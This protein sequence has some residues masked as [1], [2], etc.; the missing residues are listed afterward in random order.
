[1]AT[2]RY[3]KEGRLHLS[4]CVSFDGGHGIVEA[5]RKFF[6]WE[7]KPELVQRE[8]G[9]WSIIAPTG[10]EISA[11]IVKHEAVFVLEGSIKYDKKERE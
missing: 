6:S 4:T 7:K 5:T 2:D 10:R 8:P 9:Y 3:T 1:M 11:R